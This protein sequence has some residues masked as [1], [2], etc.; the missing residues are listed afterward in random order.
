MKKLIQLL[1]IVTSCL[2]I[3]Y[4]QVMREAAPKKNIVKIG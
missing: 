2:N 1:L 3:A 4:A